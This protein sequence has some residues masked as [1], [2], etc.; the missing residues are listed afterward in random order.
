MAGVDVGTEIVIER[1]R[2]EVAAYAADP[3]NAPAWYENIKRVEWQSTEPRTESR[4]R[5]V[6]LGSRIAFVAE[7]LGRRL[8][9][10]DEI[11]ELTPGRRWVMSTSQGPFPMETTYSWEDAPGGTRMI[12]R[13]RGT[14]SGF[15]E[16]VAP[17]MARAM[18]RVNGK[19]LE[20]VEGILEARR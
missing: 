16:V 5:R 18:R 15:S 8:E 19:D 20:K 4:T 12:L 9:Y 13:N 6:A 11:R 17:V 10:T 1:P 3:D 2:D 7:F 14:P